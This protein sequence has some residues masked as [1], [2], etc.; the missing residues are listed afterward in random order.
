MFYSFIYFQFRKSFKA[1]LKE[2]FLLCSTIHFTFEE[3]IFCLIDM[4]PSPLNQVLVNQLPLF[5]RK[6]KP[7][8]RQ[9]FHLCPRVQGVPALG[10][11]RSDWPPRQTH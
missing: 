7:S 1:I 2:N 6:L 4:I 5:K 8:I 11:G 10:C 9:V 3:F